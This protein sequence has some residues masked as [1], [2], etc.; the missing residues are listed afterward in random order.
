[1]AIKLE[2]IQRRTDYYLIDP[3]AIIVQDG[4][5][6]RTDFSGEHE[7]KRS[8]IENGVKVPLRV[9]NVDGSIILID[10]ERR[11]R[12]TLKAISEGHEIISIPAIFERKG[13]SDVEALVTALITNEG[14]P[15]DP[16]EEARGLQ[17][18]INWGLTIKDIAGKVGKSEV[19]IRNRLA[20][21][22]ASP[23]VQQ[24]V[25]E[26]TVTL[27][28]AAKITRQSG[29]NVAAQDEALKTVKKD[30]PVRRKK[31]S[32]VEIIMGHVQGMKAEDLSTLIKTL[33]EHLE[34]RVN[35]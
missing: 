29:G 24:A 33:Q 34:A 4:W 16:V 31:R 5:N 30:A 3:R 7:L 2:G 32:K 8:I 14:K 9:K 15:L 17:R 10:G 12:A 26:K 35:N 23:Q 21:T 1:M 22:D 13:I 25:Q 11:L 20:L 19:H 18:L 6:P 28:D 27:S